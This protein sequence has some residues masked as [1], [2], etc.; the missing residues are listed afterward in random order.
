MALSNGTNITEEDY[1][2]LYVEDDSAN[3]YEGK[4]AFMR[5]NMMPKV[6]IPDSIEECLGVIKS[7]KLKGAVID[8]K[9]SKWNSGSEHS[10]SNEEQAFDDGVQLAEYLFTLFPEIEIGLFSG[11]EHA[12]EQRLSQSQIADRVKIIR[13]N[14]I[15]HPKQDFYSFLPD[16]V[17]DSFFSQDVFT[18]PLYEGIKDTPIIIQSYFSKKVLGA[19]Q[20]GDFLWKAGTFA[21]LNSVNRS[22]YDHI[23]FKQ[24]TTSL[25]SDD[26]SVDKFKISIDV[27]EGKINKVFSEEDEVLMDTHTIEDKLNDHQEEPVGK[28]PRRNNLIFEYFFVNILSQM[29]INHTNEREKISDLFK[30]MELITQ[31]EIQKKIFKDIQIYAKEDF[32]SRKEI[33]K[34][35]KHFEAKGFEPVLD[36]YQGRVDVVDEKCGY[37]KLESMSPEKTTRTEKF[38]LERLAAYHLEENSRFELTIHKTSLGGHSSFIEPI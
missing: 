25:N 3:R 5:A 38:S 34:F 6:R 20:T 9:L 32:K 36:I 18:L 1:F 7:S 37:V 24:H 11:F 2:I 29:F 26:H 15:P 14:K 17:Q 8:Y 16:Y 27:N 30:N 33:L 4:E 35:L 22:I 19:M 21:W 31:F 13:Q 28:H 10:D 23:L 12:L